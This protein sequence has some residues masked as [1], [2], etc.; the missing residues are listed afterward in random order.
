MPRR[1]ALPSNFKYNTPGQPMISSMSCQKMVSILTIVL[2][3]PTNIFPPILSSGETYDYH[4]HLFRSPHLFLCLLLYCMTSLYRREPRQIVYGV[5]N[6][7]AYEMLAGK[8]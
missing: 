8:I 3:S 5:S 7:R 6:T 1:K 4:N 2:F